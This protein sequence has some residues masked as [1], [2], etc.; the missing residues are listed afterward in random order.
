VKL[1]QRRVVITGIGAVTP[2]G[3]SGEGLWEGIRRER[4]AVGSLTRFDPSPFRSH[5]AAEVNDF[6][7][8]DH[9]ERKKAKRLDRFGQFSVSSASMAVADSG[10][11]LASEDRD[12]IGTMMGTALGGVAYAESQLA[13]FLQRGVRSVDPMLA[14]TVFGGASSCNIAIELGVHGP[15]STNAMS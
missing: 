3:T 15:N 12:R 13:V 4:S 10:I 9:L 8:T 1:E 7:P 2:I 14:L 6:V 11:C 5:N